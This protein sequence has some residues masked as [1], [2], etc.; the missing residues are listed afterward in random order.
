MSTIYLDN[1]ATTRP[2]DEVADA[3]DRANRELWANPSS[4]H[5]PGQRV[6]QQLEL[7]RASVAELIGARP[8]DLVFTSG[9]TESNTLAIAGTLGTMDPGAVQA[10]EPG[11]SDTPRVALLTTAIEHSAVREPAEALRDAGA[12]VE[13]LTGDEIGRASC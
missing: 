13:M 12:P 2:A 9:G 6:R 5:R 10:V 8:R 3:V 4:V 11:A 7:A 1:N